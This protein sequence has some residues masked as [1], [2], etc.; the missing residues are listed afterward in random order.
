[1]ITTWLTWRWHTCGTLHFRPAAPPETS[2][3]WVTS[4]AQA[5]QAAA[6]L[7][8]ASAQECFVLGWHFL[9]S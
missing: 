1:M 5:N 7:P 6:L 8:S 3:E 9:H 2:P 4:P